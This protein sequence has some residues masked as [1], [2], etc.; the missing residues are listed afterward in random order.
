MQARLELARKFLFVSEYLVDTPVSGVKRRLGVGR[1][2]T[3]H[4]LRAVLLSERLDPG[5]TRQ[6]FLYRL[7]DQCEVRDCEPASG[8]SAQFSHAGERADDGNLVLLATRWVGIVQVDV[9]RIFHSAQRHLDLFQMGAH[10][11]RE[12]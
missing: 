5:K 10:L 4:Q 1:K 3:L 6:G 7:L 9:Q 12:G 8:E 11:V 2:E